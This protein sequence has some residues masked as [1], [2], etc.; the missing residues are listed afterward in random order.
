MVYDLKEVSKFGTVNN[1][2]QL[3]AC[4][5]V[6]YYFILLLLNNLFRLVA[7]NQQFISK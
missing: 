5:V 1:G 4:S 6:I 7:L 3:T 2:Q